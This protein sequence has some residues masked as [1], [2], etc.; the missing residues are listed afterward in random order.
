M[1]FQG[2]VLK[3]TLAKYSREF[4]H[5]LYIVKGQEA[6]FIADVLNLSVSTLNRALTHYN[7]RRHKTKKIDYL[8]KEFLE[9]EYLSKPVSMRSIAQ[10][11][12]ISST[13]IKKYLSKYGLEPKSKHN[14]L[15]YKIEGRVQAEETKQK[16]RD[17]WA[18]RRDSFVVKVKCIKCGKELEKE[19]SYVKSRNRKYFRCRGC[20][21]TG[22]KSPKYNRVT[23]KCCL[24]GCEKEKT[25]P[26]VLEKK[27]KFFFCC[28]EH[29][30]LFNSIY[31]VRE[32]ASAWRGGIHRHYGE[33]WKNARLSALERDGYTCTRCGKKPEK[34]ER[35]VHVHHII[36]YRLFGK[37]F[38]EIGNVTCNLQCL[39]QFCHK[40]VEMEFERFFHP[41]P[42]NYR[43]YFFWNMLKARDQLKDLHKY[44]PLIDE[45]DRLKQFKTQISGRTRIMAAKST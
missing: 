5:D 24:A 34:S 3:D 22:D 4:L 17:V 38:H 20:A 29:R 2:T 44:Y 1:K 30:N 10:K 25:F 12:G 41:L 6:A 31:F 43:L 35:Q 19:K 8:T 37:G 36:P 28:I 26:K 15:R 7:L 13:V 42:E 40:K 39:C 11:L 16:L 32:R 18:K 45:E 9:T 33:S 23:K 14:P 21:P 27:Q